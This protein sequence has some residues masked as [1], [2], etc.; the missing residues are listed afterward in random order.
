L[1]GCTLI[2]E[3][4]YCCRRLTITFVLKKKEEKKEIETW[5]MLD[6]VFAVVCFT[7]CIFVDHFPRMS[8]E[9]FVFSQVSKEMW[10]KHRRT[11]TTEMDF[12]PT[13]TY[14]LRSYEYRFS[15][16]RKRRPATQIIMIAAPATPLLD[17]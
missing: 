3:L 7:R 8:A 4:F 10:K 15:G 11:E 6:E 17:P 2:L 14:S 12:L 1:Q 16:G 5:N 13:S 9:L